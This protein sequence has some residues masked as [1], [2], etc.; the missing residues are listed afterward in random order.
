MEYARM[1]SEQDLKKAREQFD[2]LAQRN[3]ME[4]NLLLARARVNFQLKDYALAREFFEQ[5]LFLKKHTDTAHFYLGEIAQI[6]QKNNKA[7]EH[8]R[9]V[10]SGEYL[11]ATTKVFSLMMQQ[12]HRLEGQQ[13]LAEQRQAHPE[14]A[15]ALY[16]IE[17]DTLFRNNDLPRSLAALNEAIDK[18]PQQTSLYMARSL[19]HQKVTTPRQQKPIYASYLRAGDNVD[20]LNALRMLLADDNRQLDR[21]K[22]LERA[23]ALR[24]K[25]RP[26]STTWAGCCFASDKMKK[27]CA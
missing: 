10:E 23:L 20:A 11:P 21:A 3:S 26:S 8:F 18:Y 5:L 2:Y 1:L 25:T 12:N 19:V 4:S 22:L 6:D 24:L 27:P 9:R 17:A 7:L 13:W 15:Y 16:L 14:Q